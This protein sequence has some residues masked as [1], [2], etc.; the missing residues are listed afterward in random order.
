LA[1]LALVSTVFAPG[2][3]HAADE[4]PSPAA[5]SDEA[6]PK[7]DDAKAPPPPSVAIP[8]IE[9]APVRYP[10]SRVRLPLILGG[11]GFTAAAY[12][13]SAGT[14]YGSDYVPGA[15]SLYIPVVGPWMALAENRC[16]EDGSEC[17]P[18][19]YA[20]GILEALSGLAQLGGLAVAAQGIFMTT[21]AAPQ[22]RT[23]LSVVPLVT[24]TMT[25]VTVGGAF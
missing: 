9:R 11:L 15:Q 21:E 8:E 17:D 20:R 2:L 22:P 14:A 3:V 5:A 23:S 19:I 25:G 4:P 12:A 24:Q 13:A 16:P 18:M 6:E 10:P 7:S 1:T